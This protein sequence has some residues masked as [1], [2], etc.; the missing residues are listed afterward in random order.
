[1]LSSGLMWYDPDSRKAPEVKIGEAARRYRE[2][3]G[4]DPNVCHVGLEAVVGQATVPIVANRWIRPGYFWLGIDEE[5]A[6][7]RPPEAAPISRTV[8]VQRPAA[9][10]PV[11]LAAGRRSGRPFQK[12]A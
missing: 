4:A 8:L 6:M 10:A 1:M 12:S 5:L 7:A 2:R 3:F 11:P 9:A